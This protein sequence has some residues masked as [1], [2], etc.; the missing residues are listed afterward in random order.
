MMNEVNGSARIDVISLANE[1]SFDLVLDLFETTGSE[2]KLEGKPVMIC[3]YAAG[4]LIGPDKISY[5]LYFG[6][7]KGTK[8]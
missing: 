1:G 8:K 3:S 7:D 5:G 4:L 6:T 2:L